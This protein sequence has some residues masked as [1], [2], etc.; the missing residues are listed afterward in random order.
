MMII[1]HD[2]TC[3]DPEV[4]RLLVSDQIMVDPYPIYDRLRRAPQPFWSD[5]WNAWI[6]SR[7]EDVSASLRD[8][9]NL[10]NEQR[11]DLLFVGLS[12]AER[13]ALE[14][15]RYYFAQKDVIG[16]DPPD[17]VRMRALVQKTFTPRVI[18]S[19]EPRIRSITEDALRR[20]RDEG[21]T[22]DFVAHVAHPVPVTLIAEMLGAPTED[23]SLFRRWSAD[24]LGFQGTGQTSFAAASV[25]QASLLEM[26]AYMTD[27]V[28]D[29]QRH[30]RDDLI[31]ALATAEVEQVSFSRDELLATCNTLLTAGHE[32]TTNLLANLVHLLLA[33]PPAWDHVQ[34]DR[35]LV[36]SA[37][38][39]ALRYDA[40]KQR[41]FRRVS[42]THTFGAATMR[43][44]DMVFQLIGAANRDPTAFADADTFDIGRGRSNHLAF[45]SGIHFCLGAPLARLEGRVVLETL[46]D[47]RA[48]VRLQPGPIAWQ[49]RVQFRGPS[50]LFLLD[51]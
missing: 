38:E 27:L 3:E 41:N 1:R 26:F 32:T 50:A 35:S 5:S 44:G 29:R 20:A 33:N 13:V 39:E 18:A 47:T 42:R 40:P 10:S 48:R 28:D 6:V 7:Y 2:H 21:S 30:P 22:F 16:S 49:E 51:E 25:A 43:E 19:L 17:H 12:S 4:D 37:V 24:I 9:D 34:A 31:T 11:Q 14:P 15:L 45:G 46:L 8:K 23:R 36:P